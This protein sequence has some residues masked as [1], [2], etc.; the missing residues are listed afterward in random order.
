MIL[1]LQEVYIYTCIIVSW[2]RSGSI[3]SIIGDTRGSTTGL[4]LFVWCLSVTTSGPSAGEK[5]CVVAV[6]EKHFY[7][8][9]RVTRTVCPSCAYAMCSGQWQT[10][11]R[12]D[13][14]MDRQHSDLC[15]SNAP[16][17]GRSFTFRRAE[18]IWL[19]FIT[20]TTSTDI[21]LPTAPKQTSIQRKPCV[22]IF[23]T[24]VY[25]TPV[26]LTQHNNLF[27]AIINYSPWYEL[28]SRNANLKTVAGEGSN[29]AVLSRSSAVS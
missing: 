21:C 4:C 2:F 6:F 16:Q 9:K 18:Q 28:Q 13:R 14:Q 11:R 17:S 26:I 1:P 20:P 24:V 25:Q 3:Y 22:Q 29:A 15:V 5:R 8:L 19:T 7:L 23:Q 10:D 27:M 12:T